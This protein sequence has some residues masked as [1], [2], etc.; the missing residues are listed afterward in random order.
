MNILVMK[1]QNLQKQKNKN[2]KTQNLILNFET[3]SHYPYGH[4]LILVITNSKKISGFKHFYQNIRF[5]QHILLKTILMT[6]HI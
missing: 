6:H 3:P 4:Y 1:K 5:Y 2:K